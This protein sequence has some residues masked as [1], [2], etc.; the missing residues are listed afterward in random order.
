M[1]G[2]SLQDL[3]AEL[4]IRILYFC[5]DYRSIVWFSAVSRRY[6]C[7]FKNSVALQ[8]KIEL[9]SNEMEITG[10][11]THNY[12]DLLQRLRRYRDAWIDPKP[13][14]IKHKSAPKIFYPHLQLIPN[15]GM[16]RV[17][18]EWHYLD[19]LEPLSVGSTDIEE[20]AFDKEQDLSVRIH[21]NSSF[22]SDRIRTIH[23]HLQSIASGSPHPL[24]QHAVL[25]VTV[26]PRLLFIAQPCQLMRNIL[27]VIF[28]Y[29]RSRL[30]PDIVV[31]DWQSGNLLYRIVP[32]VVGHCEAA[33]LD[34][35]HLVVFATDRTEYY[36]QQRSP[37]LLIYSITPPP[38]SPDQTGP[39][40]R[41]KAIPTHTP[42]LRLEFPEILE[43]A[44]IFK[45]DVQSRLLHSNS[46]GQQILSQ[47][48]YTSAITLRLHLSM[49]QGKRKFVIFIGGSKLREYVRQGRSGTMQW[50]E[51]GEGATR[52]LENVSYDASSTP[53]PRYL[54]IS[55]S[56][57]SRVATLSVFNFH[58]PSMRRQLSQI[59]LETNAYKQ[60][61]LATRIKLIDSDNPSIV[62]IFKR[63]IV[64]RLPYTVVTKG[65][66]TPFC[67]SWVADGEY[68]VG[69]EPRLYIS[70][71]KLYNQADANVSHGAS[72]PS[73]ND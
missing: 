2:T 34:E 62:D 66:D 61:R 50:D 26:E 18:S 72:I 38:W 65:W 13:S 58:M 69:V 40:F 21:T 48:A 60:A 53:G 20:Y 46:I 49:Y 73:G 51:W 59:S 56:K 35:S 19:T 11:S 31:W 64:S 24:A 44:L 16:L 41:L 17:N 3:A 22:N 5:D 10:D 6:S 8:L 45:P 14:K 39:N 37:T 1:G 4:V 42:S 7:L 57:S 55:R 36:D 28:N 33:F 29:S 67:S 71:Y 9:D 63:Q 70:V 23:I 27:V 43:S 15:E 54:D 68:I 25:K 30:P 47:L 12:P 32:P 52:W